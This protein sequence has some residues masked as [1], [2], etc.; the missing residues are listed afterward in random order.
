MLQ[1][2]TLINLLTRCAGYLQESCRC[3]AI[4]HFHCE[5]FTLSPLGGASTSGFVSLSRDTRFAR[6]FY[7]T[8]V[9][10]AP[11]DML[12]TARINHV[13]L[14]MMGSSCKASVLRLY[15]GNTTQRASRQLIGTIVS[16]LLR[17]PHSYKSPMRH[18]STTKGGAVAQRVERWTCDQQVVGSN[19]TRGKAA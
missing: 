5:S 12:I 16:R 6:E 8:Y 7:C 1:F 18:Q 9:I 14:P 17:C 15:D 2:L 4:T 11:R 10:E 19:P 13:R 3:S